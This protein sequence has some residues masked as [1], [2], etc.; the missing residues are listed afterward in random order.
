MAQRSHGLNSC[1]F[2]KGNWLSLPRSVLTSDW[3]RGGV[4]NT[5]FQYLNTCWLNFPGVWANQG[6]AF[7]ISCPAMG[8]LPR[9]TAD[10]VSAAHQVWTGNY[11][12]TWFEFS[13]YSSNSNTKNH[14]GKLC[15]SKNRFVHLLGMHWIFGSRKY[16]RH[17]TAQHCPGFPASSTVITVL[18][19]APLYHSSQS[20][21]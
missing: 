15:S 21:L 14:W 4:F 5:S 12:I 19:D 9:A 8:W 7:P 17:R 16:M 2:H 3:V 18:C 20:P 6:L 1:S 13:S 11:F 10:T